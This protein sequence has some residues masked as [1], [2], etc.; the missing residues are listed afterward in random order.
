M[1]V[2]KVMGAT[3]LTFC[4]TIVLFVG[5]FVIAINVGFGPD[6][7]EQTLR[8]NSEFINDIINEEQFYSVEEFYLFDDAVGEIINLD[9]VNE[10]FIKL[11]VGIFDYL[12]FDAELPQIT[13]DEFEALIREE[14]IA[15]FDEIELEQWAEKVNQSVEEINIALVDV[16]YVNDVLN[17]E[18]E[19]IRIIFNPETRTAIFGLALVIS[20]LIALVLFSLYRPL[21]WVGSAAIIAGGLSFLIGITSIGRFSDEMPIV[22]S[23]IDNVLIESR[24]IGLI[25]IG[26]GILL[27]I[28][29]FVLKNRFIQNKELD[30]Q[31]DES[32]N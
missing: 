23:L 2:L 30:K 14:A 8:D 15:H 31:L 4:L 13:N 11:T 27:I 32:F 12:L 29:Y 1:K 28:V 3:I 6:K 20:L 17:N 18:A 21:A 24:N 26:I 7:I 10:L 16:I 22:R 25:S 5:L 9:E 19:Q